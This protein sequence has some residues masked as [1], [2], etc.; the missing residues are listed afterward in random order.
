MADKDPRN[1]DY[2]VGRGRPPKHSQFKKFHSGNP[3]GRP[4]GGRDF[5]GH[6]ERD[7]R[8]KVKVVENGRTRSISKKEMA[9]RQLMKRAT[10]GDLHAIALLMKEDAKLVQRGSIAAL[11][12]PVPEIEPGACVRRRALPSGP[13]GGGQQ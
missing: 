4:K 2:V 7:G 6:L 1:D 8:R 11:A 3:A 9:A 10:Q 5:S 12:L 13:Y